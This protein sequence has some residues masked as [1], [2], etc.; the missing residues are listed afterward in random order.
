MKI[1]KN[2]N[3]IVITGKDKGKKAKVL[4]AFPKLDMVLVEGV[5]LKKK[6]KKSTAGAG[7][8]A[9]VEMAHP[10]HV[11]NVKIATQK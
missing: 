1:K 8:G 2:D 5:N 4:K 7:K 10:I 11:S 9:V 3:I 6:H